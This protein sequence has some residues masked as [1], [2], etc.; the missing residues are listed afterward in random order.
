MLL[1]NYKECILVHINRIISYIAIIYTTN[2]IEYILYQLHY[3]I[4]HLSHVNGKSKID[5][6]IFEHLHFLYTNKY[7]NF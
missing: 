4:S 6:S 2:I 1:F 3:N 5:N 7:A